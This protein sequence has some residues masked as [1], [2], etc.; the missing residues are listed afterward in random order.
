MKATKLFVIITFLLFSGINYGKAQRVILS[1]TIPQS[2]KKV[3]F[4]KNRMHYSALYLSL[5]LNVSKANIGTKNN[6]FYLETELGGLYKV[7]INEYLST[8][9]RVGFSLNSVNYTPGSDSI[10][11]VQYHS[12]LVGVNLKNYN[13]NTGL[14]LRFNFNKR[15][16]IAGK[17]IELQ[18]LNKYK[19][20]QQLKSKYE[21]TSGYN[22]TIEKTS[23]AK[24]D[25]GIRLVQGLE[26]SY[27]NNYM[28]V[29]ARYYFTDFLQ[30]ELN[31]PKFYFG[32]RLNLDVF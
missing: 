22:T 3:L 17:Y 5:G 31:A 25:D 16:A 29:Y 11:P 14:F 10:F 26:L 24:Y 27:N 30:A 28:A 9:L 12:G 13:L 15:G 2:K 1:D 21:D 20:F 23:I 7:K 32:L 8:G 19:L 18:F 6:A 4:G